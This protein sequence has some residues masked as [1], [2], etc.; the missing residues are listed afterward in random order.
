MT[1]GRPP[2]EARGV[3]QGF[4]P[5]QTL[6]D[7]FRD[8]RRVARLTCPD[9]GGAVPVEVQREKP[10]F[11]ECRV[12]HVY[13]LEELLESKEELLE[14]RLWAAVYLME[15]LAGLLTDLDVL[16]LRPGADDSARARRRHL[17]EGLGALRNVIRHDVPLDLRSE[18]SGEDGRPR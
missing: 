13:S 2:E 8:G 11:F 16:R 5:G 3:E 12:G 7:P 1:A 18:Q 17:Q 9:C 15:E 14:R 10:L 4:G 6:P